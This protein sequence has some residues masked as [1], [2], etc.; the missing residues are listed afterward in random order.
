MQLLINQK[1]SLKF[2]SSQKKHSRSGTDPQRSRPPSFPAWFL[3]VWGKLWIFD[4]FCVND[5][6]FQFIGLDA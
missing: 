2:F 4:D 3:F 1:K 5:C 6:K